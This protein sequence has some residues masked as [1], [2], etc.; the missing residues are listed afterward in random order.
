MIAEAKY[1]VDSETVAY[2]REELDKSIA[3]YDQDLKL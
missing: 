1:K 2:L 3:D